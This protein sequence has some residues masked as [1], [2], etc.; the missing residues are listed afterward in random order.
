L[1]ELLHRKDGTPADAETVESI[2]IW[3][4]RKQVENAQ[5][6]QKT[7][8][9]EDV[10]KRVVATK[11]GG[12]EAFERSI[13]SLASRIWGLYGPF[14]THRKFDY[15]L[16]MPGRIVETS[17]ELLADD[18]TRWSF[19]ATEAYPL[20]YHMRSRSLEPNVA[21]MKQLLGGQPLNSRQSLLS[22]VD[23]V[24]GNDALLTALKQ[25]VN[26]QNMSPLKKCRAKVEAD[27]NPPRP[28]NRIVQIQRLWKLLKM[29]D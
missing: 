5:G 16:E 2:L 7:S 24:G 23:I 19:N 3:L 27:N 11:Y 13:L 28:G 1:R 26:S 6:E 15:S 9:L 22:Y 12:K 18:R 8:P 4:L 25:C 29:S 20:G 14:R 17:G 21:A 10:A